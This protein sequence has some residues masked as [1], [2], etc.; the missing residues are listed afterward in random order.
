M[1]SALIT[2]LL[3]L[4]AVLL[5]VCIVLLLLNRKKIGE[6]DQIDQAA[7]F[8]SV[9]DK[10][11]DVGRVTS[12]EFHRSRVET[13]GNKDAIVKQISELSEKSLESQMNL[14]DR[15]SRSL[16]E[17]R[18]GNEKKLDEMR[19]TVDE[20]LTKTLTTRLD[21]SF[22]TVS[23]QLENLYK[24]LGEMKELSAGVTTN[25]SSLNRIL[26]NVKA[27]GTWAEVQLEAILDQTIPGMYEKNV[28]TRQGSLARVEF[29]VKIPSGEDSSKFAYL[30]IDSKFPM[31]DYARLCEAADAADAPALEAARKALET[32]VKDEAKQISAYINEPVTTPFAI[33]YLATEGLYA[34]VTSSKNG[35]AEEVQSKYGI[36]VAGPTTITALL[37]SLSMGF[38]AIA[39]NEKAN[40]VRELLSVTKAQY[41]KFEEIL[42]KAQS[43]ITDAGKVL[44]EAQHR[45]EI[46]N[47]KLKKVDAIEM[48]EAD[49]YLQID[50]GFDE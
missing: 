32:R 27:R 12:E 26:T 7:A 39:I 24:S 1:N 45:N 48:G 2:I 40:E 21:S 11:R 8:R 29:A 35:L 15:I 23:E 38:R 41:G 19:Q 47:K 5:I 37:N 6:I 20:K 31:E 42:A 34:E 25:V 30:P 17:I 4:I 28:A 33:M 3:V 10:I 13:A 49:A 14:G 50:D 36:M 43:K 16:T 22:K 9:E 46:I 18:E 44:G